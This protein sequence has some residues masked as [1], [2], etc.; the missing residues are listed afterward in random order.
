MSLFLKFIN[1][2]FKMFGQFVHAFQI[3]F[4]KGLELLNG[5]ENINQFQDSSAKEIKFTEDLSF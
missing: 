4:G 5:V 3:V 2:L 1:D